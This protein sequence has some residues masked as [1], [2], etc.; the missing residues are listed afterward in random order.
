[1]LV[2]M[3]RSNIDVLMK[4]YLGDCVCLKST[5][6]HCVDT[7]SQHTLNSLVTEGTID[8]MIIPMMSTNLLVWGGKGRARDLGSLLYGHQGD[9]WYCH[10]GGRSALEEL[11]PV[12]EELLASKYI[13]I[14][15]VPPTIRVSTV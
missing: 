11:A 2:K 12:H 1:M 4:H 7:I 5:H 6:I 14:K 10:S 15:K 13:P 9:D 3:N 8:N